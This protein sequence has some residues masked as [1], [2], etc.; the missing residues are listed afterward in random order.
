VTEDLANAQLSESALELERSLNR[1]T[2][3]AEIA[4]Q[5]S[6]PVQSFLRLMSSHDRIGMNDKFEV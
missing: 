3:Q 4:V 1:L 5:D 2:A 6:D